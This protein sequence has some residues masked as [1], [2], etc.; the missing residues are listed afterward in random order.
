MRC[1]GVSVALIHLVDKDERAPNRPGRGAAVHWVVE[2][3]AER[4]LLTVGH[5]RQGFAM[6]AIRA[7]KG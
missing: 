3:G 7:I 2:A 6:A 1:Q 5:F 4:S